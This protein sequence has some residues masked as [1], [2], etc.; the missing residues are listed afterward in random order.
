MIESSGP[1]KAWKPL[2]IQ[3]GRLSEAHVSFLVLVL[4][5]ACR[6]CMVLTT[7]LNIGYNIINT[8]LFQRRQPVLIITAKGFPVP[9]NI[10]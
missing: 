4:F 2:T 10:F 5:G 9:Q 7:L 1:P 8:N 6:F 3:L